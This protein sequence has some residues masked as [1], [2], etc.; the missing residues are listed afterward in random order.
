MILLWQCSSPHLFGRPANVL[1]DT[2]HTTRLAGWPTLETSNDVFTRM[3]VPK[4]FTYENEFHSIS[5]E[6]EE[7]VDSPHGHP[8]R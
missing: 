2:D 4:P 3:N 6:S 5:Y 1:Y 7:M 8:G